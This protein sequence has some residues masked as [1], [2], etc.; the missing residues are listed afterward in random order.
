MRLI[1]AFFIVWAAVSVFVVSVGI[2][3]NTGGI[4]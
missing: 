4:M 1:Y 2:I 3:K